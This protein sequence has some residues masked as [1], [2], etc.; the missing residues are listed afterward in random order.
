MPREVHPPADIQQTQPR[1]PAF[2]AALAAVL[3]AV[4]AEE[5][6]GADA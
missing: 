1:S 5:S 3:V 6:D 4:G 2:G